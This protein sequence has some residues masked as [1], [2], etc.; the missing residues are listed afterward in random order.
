MTQNT[1]EELQ[2][3]SKNDS[4]LSKQ[5]LNTNI[6]LYVSAESGLN[7]RTLPKGD[8][9]GKFN[10]ND[11]VTLLKRTGVFE[12]IIDENKVIKGEWVGVKK[13]NDTVYVFD[14]FLTKEKQYLDTYITKEIIDYYNEN[15]GKGLVFSESKN[16]SLRHLNYRSIPEGDEEYGWTMMSV[17]IPRKSNSKYIYKGDINNDGEIDIIVPVNTEGGGGGGNVWWLDYFIFL[18]Q[19]NST[20]KF[21]IEKNNWESEIT[22]CSDNGFM[23]IDRIEKSIIYAESSCYTSEDGRCC[24]SLSFKT[25]LKFEN[26]SLV[27]IDKAQVQ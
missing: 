27:V 7:Y 6:Q 21:A 25:K 22:G 10:L 20:Y 19:K 14:G 15:F 3:S 5:I 26:N 8:I 23:H 2:K 11:K 13:D 9:K 17:D 12:K 1:I 18:K 16:D 24:P 4:T